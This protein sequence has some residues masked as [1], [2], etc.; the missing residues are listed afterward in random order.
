MSDRHKAPALVHWSVWAL[1]AVAWFATLGSRPLFEPDEGRYAEIPREMYVSG[2]WVTPRL[3]GLKYFEKPV[4]QYWATAAVYSV[5]GVHEWSSR[6]WSSTLAFLCVPMVYAFARRVYRSESAG[7]AAAAILAVNPY[8]VIVGQL[9]LLDSGLCFFLTASAFAYLLAGDCS[10]GSRAERNWMLWAAAALALAILSKGPV[11]L[12]LAGVTV[13]V[14]AIA[15][16]S[17]RALHRWWLRYTVPLFLLICAPWFIAVSLRNPEFP[18]FFFVHEHI[19]RFLTDVHERVE[20]WWYF[21]PCIFL[22]TLPWIRTFVRS[23]SKLGIAPLRSPLHSIPW[24]LAIL[25]GVV[26]LFFSASHS[27][28]APYVLPMMPALAVVLAPTMATQKGASVWAAWISATLFALLGIGLCISAFH[29][30]DGT[31]TP[32]IVWTV[33]AGVVGFAA[34]LLSSRAATEIGICVSAALGTI[35]SAQALMMAFAY[36]PPGQSSKALLAGVRPFIGP[37]TE[38]FSVDQ[39]RQS[40]PPYLGRTLRLVRYEGEMQFG[41]GRAGGGTFIPSLDEFAAIWMCSSDALAFVDLDTMDN[42]KARGL[43]FELRA[44]DGRTAAITRN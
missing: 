11:A 24:F 5:F 37:H 32:M 9:N 34:A 28:L 22:A 31:M 42:L 35:L 3:N 21:I 2:D 26:F 44:V 6:L 41:I 29:H 4:L 16:G 7:I 19:D 15:T 17:I 10:P 39:Y 30:R 1:L 18:Q 25:S 40:I 8:F 33:G 23:P 27:K 38:L 13:V 36:F 20:P 43:P 12:L 14:H